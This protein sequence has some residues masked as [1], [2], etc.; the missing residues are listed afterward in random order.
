MSRGH[1]GGGRWYAMR[2]AASRKQRVERQRAWGRRTRRPST[3][4]CCGHAPPEK[5]TNESPRGGKKAPLKNLLV[6]NKGGWVGNANG[7]Q[8]EWGFATQERTRLQRKEKTKTT[9]HIELPRT[10]LNA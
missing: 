6:E 3:Q 2:S 8:F 10:S 5:Q 4:P 9:P 1:G 7:L